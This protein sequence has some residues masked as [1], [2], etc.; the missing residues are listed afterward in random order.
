MEQKPRIC[1]QC[2]HN[3]AQT[4]YMA[5][6]PPPKER[7]LMSHNQVTLSS[8]S[9][10]ISVLIAL[11]NTLRYAAPELRHNIQ[12]DIATVLSNLAVLSGVQESA[13]E[14][15][16][17]LDRTEATAEQMIAMRTEQ[18][19][20]EQ[21]PGLKDV[22]AYLDAKES[23]Y[24]LSTEHT[25]GAPAEGVNG[26]AAKLLRYFHEEWCAMLARQPT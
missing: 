9:E 5:S 21:S 18:M 12:K 25:I 6:S 23:E 20:R 8:P 4:Q 1:E 11:F 26:R 24:Q 16:P 17:K 3:P 10:Q 13:S 15:V 7:H 2:K 14:T 22:L 19:T